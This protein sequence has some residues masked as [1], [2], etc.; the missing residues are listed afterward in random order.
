MIELSTK[1]SN[2]WAPFICHKLGSKGSRKWSFLYAIFLSV[3]ELGSP[4]GTHDRMK[5]LSRHRHQAHASCISYTAK[6]HQSP[7][8]SETRVHTQYRGRAGIFPLRRHPCTYDHISA[9]C[10]RTGTSICI[11][12]EAWLSPRWNLSTPPLQLFCNSHHATNRLLYF[13]FSFLFNC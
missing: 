5:V 12:F 3:F 13:P 11:L 7:S 4:Y 10:H 8:S 2:I 6:T 1:F 9:V